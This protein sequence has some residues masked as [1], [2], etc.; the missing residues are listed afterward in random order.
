MVVFTREKGG[1]FQAS[2][3][4]KRLFSRSSTL[5]LILGKALLQETK[6]FVMLG[7]QDLLWVCLWLFLG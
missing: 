3:A 7:S 6:S 2:Q 4:W 5:P 1:G